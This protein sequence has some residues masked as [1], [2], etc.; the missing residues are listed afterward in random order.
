MELN[1]LDR[2]EKRLGTFA[3]PHLTFVLV[4]GQ[5]C[6][7][8]FG[9]VDARILDLLNFDPVL[10]QSG[11]VWRIVTFLFIPP[12]MHPISAFFGLYLFYLMGGAL[13]AEWGYFRYNIYIFTGSLATVISAFLAQDAVV[14]NAY[15]G[16]SVFLAFA[17]LYPNFE[18]L[19]F[20]I[21]PIK[22][23]YLAMFTWIIYGFSF[24]TG[25]WMTRFLVFASVS[26][27][28]LF[29]GKRILGRMRQS[30]RKMSRD[31]KHLKNK[32]Q[33]FHICQSCKKTERTDPEED[34]RVCPECAGGEEYC[35][36]HI[37]DHEHVTE[38]R[39]HFM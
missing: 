38:A 16:G 27:F 9:H 2:L 4:M 22:V 11:E 30:Q 29:F 25:D 34:F 12:S 10:F 31:V 1:F 20:F 35:Q 19:L 39:G 6:I 13:E 21:L 7:F 24:V 32:M 15:I 17:Y 33:P 8:V 5:L 14:T 18:I 26:N 28:F 3:I 23:R 37:F 36:E